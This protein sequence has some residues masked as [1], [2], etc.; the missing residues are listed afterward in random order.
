MPLA[1]IGAAA[2]R[3]LLFVVGR[4]LVGVGRG[5]RQRSQQP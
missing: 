5:G 4:P 1:A 3:G 2:Y